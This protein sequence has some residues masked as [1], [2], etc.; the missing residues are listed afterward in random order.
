LAAIRRTHVIPAL[1]GA[2]FLQ[3]RARPGGVLMYAHALSCPR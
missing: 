3:R 1:C 2:R